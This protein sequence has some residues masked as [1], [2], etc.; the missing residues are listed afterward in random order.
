MET[1]KI[2]WPYLIGLPSSLASRSLPAL[3]CSFS[4][5]RKCPLFSSKLPSS[6]SH[7]KS[8]SPAFRFPSPISFS[9]T[10]VFFLFSDVPLKN[11]SQPVSS[12]PS[13][14]QLYCSP[15][16]PLSTIQKK[17]PSQLPPWQDDHLIRHTSH[18]AWA[19]KPSLTPP[20]N[21]VL[22]SSSRDDMNTFLCF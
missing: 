14:H 18:A 20:K 7:P 3:C 4:S 1:R 19:W 13:L 11:L 6:N 17:S 2:M 10:F 5:K 15:S 9:L 8:L 12:P 16:I 21:E 22:S